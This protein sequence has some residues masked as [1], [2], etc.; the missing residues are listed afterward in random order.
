MTML[1]NRMEDYYYVSQGKTRIPGVNDAEELLVTEV[2]RAAAV[3]SLKSSSDQS[4]NRVSLFF[5]FFSLTTF[6]A[7]GT[8]QNLYA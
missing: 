1:G 2:S 4:T 8:Y 6:L 7:F 3:N 5:V